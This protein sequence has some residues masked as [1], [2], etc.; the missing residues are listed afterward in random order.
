MEAHQ[1][2]QSRFLDILF[3][4]KNKLYGA[5]DLRN[6]YNQRITKSLL[7]TLV[8]IS[9][10]AVSFIISKKFTKEKKFVKI[11]T[12]ETILQK[13]AENKPKTMPKL[14]T[15]VQVK[16][17]QVTTPA[18]VKDKLVVIPPPNVQQIENAVIGLKTID[19]PKPDLG[20]VN[21]PTAI[22]GTNVV[23]KPVNKDAHEKPFKPVEIE[24][25]FPGGPDAWQK[26][27]QRAIQRQVDEFTDADYGTCVVK[28]K[29]DVNGNVSNVEA[30]T[31][32]GTKLAEI[33]VNTIRKGP[34]WIPAMQNG[35]YVTADRYQPVTLL[36]PNQ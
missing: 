33:S 8:F 16:T 5:Y 12:P 35:T 20:V 25:Q 18:I 10:L 32:K 24:A 1:I 30:T 26:Y 21:P 9:V 29:V 11:D 4:G 15:H 3:E 34:K 28:F 19:G 2:L 22:A 23:S 7:A 31:M 14:P 36:N 13:I 17:L 27:I 6:T